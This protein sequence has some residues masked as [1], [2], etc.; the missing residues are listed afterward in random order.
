M[1]LGKKR[2]NKLLFFLYVLKE[3]K[4]CPVSEVFEEYIKPI[5]TSRFKVDFG[6]DYAKVLRHVKNVM[7]FDKLYDKALKKLKMMN[8]RRDYLSDTCLPVTYQDN[9]DFPPPRNSIVKKMMV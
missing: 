8:G 5:E 1:E 9:K 2:E 4:E 6:E 3:E 7:K